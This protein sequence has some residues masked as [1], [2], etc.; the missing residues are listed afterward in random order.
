MPDTDQYDPSAGNEQLAEARQKTEDLAKK[1]KDEQDASQQ[2]PATAPA[3]APATAPAQAQPGAAAGGI[4]KILGSLET[5][6]TISKTG[7][8]KLHAGE[9]V[10]PKGRASE[11]RKVFKQRGQSGKHKYG[12]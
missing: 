11:Y 7:N 2:A 10:L 12:A 8:Y 9:E 3:Q 4:K 1:Q 5:G 6:G